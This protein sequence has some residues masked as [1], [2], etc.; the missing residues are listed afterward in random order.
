MTRI[1]AF[2]ACALLGIG[3]VG[4]G[5]FSGDSLPPSV[6][7]DSVAVRSFVVDRQVIEQIEHQGSS[8][9]V[10]DITFEYDGGR[11]ETRRYV[12]IGMRRVACNGDCQAALVRGLAD[13]SEG[14]DDY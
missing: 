4:C 8:Y 3:L 9:E 1:R 14:D 13:D 7:G 12:L 5:A 2:L 10:Q 11:R 6:G